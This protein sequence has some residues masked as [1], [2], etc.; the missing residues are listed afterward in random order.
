MY[1]HLNQEQRY[2]IAGLRKAGFS[3]RSLAKEMRLSPSTI[4]REVKRNSSTRSYH[5]ARAQSYAQERQEDKPRRKK[6]TPAMQKIIEERLL[7]K[8]SPEQI[9]GRCQAEQKPMV[10][11]E[12]IYQWIWEDKQQGGKWWKHLRHGH[13]KYRK[14]Y[15][16]KDHRGQIPHKISIDKRPEIVNQKTRMGDWEIDTIIGKNNQGAILT[17]V[18][19]KTQFTLMAKL[20]SKSYPEVQKEII[21]LLAPYK[22][23]LHTITSDN[24]TEFY[25]HQHIAQKLG[26]DYYFAHPYS[27][28]ERGL[29]EY[30][31]KLIRQYIPKKEDF[32]NYTPHQIIQIQNELNQ[33]P[34]KKL[35][36]QTP[37]ELFLNY[38][39]A[40]VS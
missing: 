6:W 1:K 14:R 8:W 27:S 4:S 12:R 35:N 17:A 36:Y 22:T 21:N 31:N 10:S 37:N 40:L 7:L 3:L 18:E 16:K 28:W 13:K 19:R 29:N 32:K 15:G 5:A 33:R 9:A 34:R 26:I 38:S 39:V 20:P 23:H 24:G 2:Q 25:G 30:H 11:H